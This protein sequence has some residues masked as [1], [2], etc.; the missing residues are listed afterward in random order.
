MAT[1]I[2]DIDNLVGVHHPDQPLRKEALSGL[3]Q[4]KQAYLILEDGFIAAVGSM[5][6]LQSDPAAFDQVIDASKHQVLPAWCDSHTHLVFAAYREEEFVDKIRGLSYAEIAANGGGI[7][8]SAQ[9]LQQT[10]EDQ[11]FEL[12][13][14]RL[15]SAIRLGTGA[16]EIK[17]GYGLTIDA[18]L[19][20]LRV[21]KR[22]KAASPIPIK[23]TFLGAHALPVAYRSDREGYLRL[24]IDSLLPLVAAESLADYIDVFCEEGFFSPE[25]TDRLLK[26]GASFGLKPKIHA[27]QLAVSGGVEVGVRNQAR[28]V[29]H[30]ECLDQ[31]AID[32][33]SESST[34]GT[35]L[36]ACALFLRAPYPPARKLIDR[37][38]ALAIASDFNPGSSPSYNMNLVVALACSQLRMLPEEAI[39]A[40][41]IQGAFAMDLQNEVGSIAVGKRANFIFTKPMRSL[42]YLPYAFGEN[43]VDRVMIAGIFQD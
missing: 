16:I 24:L 5:C 4:L 3:P 40:A 1:L 36:P 9:K 41:T 20:M 6:D 43:P 14:L 31:A 18:E 29:D 11:L 25:E 30:L 17:S 27:N 33:L 37:G 42:A 28:S 15:Q 8:N 38:A 32:C 10:S 21:I 12:A 34:M 35:L 22:L 2:R 7:L 26:A 19:K 23:S 39:N 13:W